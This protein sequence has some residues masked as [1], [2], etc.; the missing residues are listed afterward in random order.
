VFLC[1]SSLPLSIL[2]T[3]QNL[4]VHDLKFIFHVDFVH[5][6]YLAVNAGLCVGWSSSSIPEYSQLF[7]LFYEGL[8]EILF[9]VVTLFIYSEIRFYS[10]LPWY[11]KCKRTYSEISAMRI[12]FRSSGHL[13]LPRIPRSAHIFLL[14]LPLSYGYTNDV[15][16][17]QKEETSSSYTW[18][19]YLWIHIHYIS[20]VIFFL[21]N[22]FI[23]M[24]VAYLEYEWDFISCLYF[25][26]SAFTRCGEQGIPD[27]A[28][29]FS[30]IF[31]PFCTITGNSS[32]AL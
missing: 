24:L 27:Y 32:L 6:F 11:I 22:V 8:G 10:R 17:E 2:L 29:Q 7:T 14:Y 28:N 31:I 26:I 21:L 23:I 13:S 20:V 1:H 5:A 16:D 30:L 9:A 4:A 19:Q 3:L 12:I 18:S 15:D 25:A